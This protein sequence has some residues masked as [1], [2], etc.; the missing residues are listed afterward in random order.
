MPDKPVDFSVIL[1]SPIH[2]MIEEVAKGI[3]QAQ[4]ELDRAAMES[5]KKLEEDFPELA[6]IGYQVTWYQIPE[7]E[8][9]LKVAVHYEIEEETENKKGFF[10]SPFNA[11]YKNNYSYAADGASSLKLR[12]VPVPP[13]NLIP[14]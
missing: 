6:D 9:E 11:K 1:V 7:A 13:K 10:L 3:A 14:E 2:N 12:F 5:Q 8:V 4:T